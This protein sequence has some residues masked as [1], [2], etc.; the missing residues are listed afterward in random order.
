MSIT[1][2]DGNTTED[3][4]ELC[5]NLAVE[6]FRSGLNCC[7]SVFD[8][9]IRAGVVEVP[10]EATAMCIGFGGGIGLTGNNCGALSAI[11]MANG[12]KYGRIDPWSVPAEERLSEVADKYYRRYNHIVSDF[13]KEF[14]GITCADICEPYG[15]WHSKERK[16][17]CLKLI[18]NSAKLA[19]DYLM[20]SQEVAFELTYQENIANRED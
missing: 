10:K 6:S 2:N 4:R 16:K 19:Y 13:K 9:L 12:A 18:A 1:K 8:A 3:K 14:G 5:G 17:N 15:D 20:M 7:E 11:I